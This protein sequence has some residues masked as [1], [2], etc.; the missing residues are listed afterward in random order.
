MRARIY[1][2][3]ELLVFFFLAAIMVWG[4]VGCSTFP[5]GPSGGDGHHLP[6]WNQT[7]LM[8]NGNGLSFLVFVAVLGIGAGVAAMVVM[9]G[10]DKIPWGIISGSAA[11]LGVA[12]FVK[13]SLGLI[14][15]IVGGTLILGLLWLAGKVYSRWR[16]NGGKD[17]QV[18]TPPPGGGAGGQSSNE[19]GD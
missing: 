18:H 15:W 16:N 10:S 7:D 5:K 2:A 11:V 6:W 8:N 14:P 3:V 19:T 13:A 9:P 17:R 12:L 4:I 1:T